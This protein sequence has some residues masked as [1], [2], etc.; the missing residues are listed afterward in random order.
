M[1]FRAQLIG[2]GASNIPKERMTKRN[3]DE[4][5]SLYNA[6]MRAVVAHTGGDDPRAMSEVSRLCARAVHVVNDLQARVLIRGVESQARLL[7]SADGHVGVEAG[8][9][10]GIAALKFRML[11]A[12]SNFRG[13]LQMLRH[14]PSKPELPA[15]EVKK[16]SRILVVEDDPDSALSLQ[17]LLELCGYSV[18]IAYSAQEGLEAAERALPDIV[19]CDIGLPGTDGY[20]FA[21]ALRN[22]P[23]TSRVR[24]IAVTAY[25]SEQDKERS[26]A[27]GFHL[28]LVKPVRPENLLEELD[29]PASLDAA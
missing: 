7:F 12:L 4:A 27:A 26:R 1:H 29:R 17:R 25:G 2:F 16:N 23:R 10:Q 11:T 6:L 19:L 18:T 28:H 21:A 15:L 22:T 13:R 8:P 5:H 14:A 9:L 24:L 3:L 20:E